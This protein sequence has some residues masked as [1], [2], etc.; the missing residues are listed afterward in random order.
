MVV[1]ACV[2]A[3][4][5]ALTPP[6]TSK[7]TAA[8][9]NDGKTTKLD[10]T[11]LAEELATNRPYWHDPRIHQG[12]GGN[13]GLGGRIAS[14]MAPLI[15]K[16]IDVAAYGGRNVRAECGL[17]ART[18]LVLGGGVS[19]PLTEAASAGAASVVVDLGCGTGASTR[20]LTDAFPEADV[21]AFDTSPPF[22]TTARLLTNGRPFAKAVTFADRNAEATGLED[23]AADVVSI[24]FVM[25]EAPV[26][27]RAALLAEA[28]RILRPGGLLM[29][30][31]IAQEYSPS[32]AMAAGEPYVWGYMKNIKRD[33]TR[34]GFAALDETKVIPNHATLWL[35]RKDPRPSLL[36][37]AAKNN[38]L[39]LNLG[40]G[41]PARPERKAQLASR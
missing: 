5:V 18:A 29:V 40:A 34:A 1:V 30:L 36:P 12:M 15:T 32:P 19:G 11:M 24:Q 3:S 4:A 26:Q 16:V 23:G 22:L 17:S 33:L 9:K 21:L 39:K 35:C 10:A 14:V 25:H 41:L 8:P 20:A 2:C 6:S 13:I 7:A 38:I 28:K 27:G 31:D 37:K